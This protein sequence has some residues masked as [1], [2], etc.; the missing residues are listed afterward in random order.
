VQQP[1]DIKAMQFDPT[2]FEI[3]K[4]NFHCTADQFDVK[5]LHLQSET[6]YGK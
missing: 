5:N 2:F 3:R 6:I 1:T 4:V